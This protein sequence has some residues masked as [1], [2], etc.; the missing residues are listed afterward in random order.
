MLFLHPQPT[1]GQLR[2]IYGADYY[3]GIGIG[4]GDEE[5]SRQ[6]KQQTFIRQLQK[7]SRVVDGGRVLDVGCA[8][9]FFLEVAAS[10]GWDVY[11]AEFSRFAAERA[12]RRFGDRI[13][14]GQIKDASYPESFF[15][16]V[17]LFD[18][19]EHVPDPR[20]FLI[21][22]RRVLRPGGALLA[23]MPDAVS[24]SARLMGRHWSHY[25]MEHLHYFSPET[26]TRLLSESGFAIHCVESARKSL[27]LSYVCGQIGRQAPEFAKKALST[28]DALLPAWIKHWNIAVPCGQMLVLARNQKPALQESG[29]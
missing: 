18:L 21:E 10:A 14:Y 22:V 11:G 8:T 29:I 16:A 3:V 25:S 15:D 20:E 12:R 28:A 24:L 4:G 27:N 26:A 2:E 9:G 17:T 1:S 13:C 5:A 7:L 19:L 6:M 23:V